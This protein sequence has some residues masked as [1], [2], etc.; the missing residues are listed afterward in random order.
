MKKYH[1]L[2][3]CW[4][5]AGLM[6]F[7]SAHALPQEAY[8]AQKDRINAE[9]KAQKEA[10]DKLSGNAK[11]ICVE[12]AKGHEK[13]GM[14]ELEYTHRGR[15]K[16]AVKVSE[17]K[18][19]AAYAVSKERCDD[20]AGNEKDVCVKEAKAAHEK[21]KADAKMN[22]QVGEAKTEAA[23]DK[24]EAEYQV[25]VEKCDAMTG[26]AKSSCVASAKARFG[27]S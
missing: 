25:A 12:E 6:A 4:A 15:D 5:A 23:H 9:Y 18:A 27:K 26:D 20:K 7:A 8:K 19:D 10:C 11:D 17:A 22:K 1:A 3:A 16:E 24:R 2:S 21:A 13:V 14:A